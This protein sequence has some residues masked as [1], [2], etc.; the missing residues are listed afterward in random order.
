MRVAFL[1]L[2]CKVNQFE[3]DTMSG[4][5]GK[6]GHETVP[7]EDAADAYVINT[8]AVTSLSE[9]KSRQMIRR[10][11]RRNPAAVI[12]VAGCYAQI[13]PEEVRQL[14][15]DVI[16]GAD[17]RGKIVELVEAATDD[18]I[19][20]RAV[21]DY[22]SLTEFEDIPLTV[23]PSRTRAFLKIEDGC[24]NFCSYCV[25]PYA[26]G[27]V[28]SRSLYSV[29][30]ETER[31]A[32]MGFGEIVLTGIHLGA[33]G[34]DLKNG[35]NLSA[36]CRAVLDVPG[37]KRLRLSS[38]ESIELDAEVLSL[39]ESDS[40]FCRHLHL[41]LQSGSDEVLR[42]MNR[43]YGTKDFAELVAEIRRRL[44]DVAVSTDII[45][46]FPGETD[47]LFAES[48]EFAKSRNFSRIHVFPYSPR[49]GTPAAAMKNQVPP[50]LKKSRAAEM[51]KA[52]EEA[53]ANF[54]EG[55]IGKTL[56]VLFET[57]DER[58]GETDGLTGNY[59]RV[60]I[61]GKI[62][63]GEIIPVKMTGVCRDGLGGEI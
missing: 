12:A 50:S 35:E 3:T 7:F 31:F 30:R 53:A 25:I 34:R 16:I 9:R 19:F 22:R 21:K 43:H 27:K 37:V 39:M 6:K 44:P 15:I 57:Y 58:T 29:K 40:R 61:K 32:A 48:L 14:G 51:Q 63:S 4:L 59:V 49:R 17:E 26:R 55:F 46:G 60:Y 54:A 41:P 11:R 36:A 33:Y 56:P 8:C 5:F 2:G 1:T 28:R 38:L 13:R 45:V 23:T 52:A 18:R 10:A 47:E 20:R 24:E 62:P 42:A